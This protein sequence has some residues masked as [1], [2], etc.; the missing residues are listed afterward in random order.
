MR[1]SIRLFKIADIS[2]NV[3]ITF[4]LLLFLFLSMGFRW[5]FLIVAIFCFVILHELA[6]S[7]VAKKFGIKVNEITL[8]PIGGIASMSKMPDKPYQEFLISLA[9][10]MLNIG[11]VVIFFFPLYY[12]LGPEVLFHPLSVKTL[13]LTIAHIYWINLI[14]AAF[15]LIPAF[16]MDGG[17]ILR[18]LLAR[19]MGYRKATK[20]AVNFGHIFA[21]I[22]G[23]F[24]LVQGHIILI[25]IAIFIYMAASS[26]E[27]Q[28]DIRET[29]KR[30]TIK[31]IISPKF[32]TLQK[33]ATLAKVLELIFHSHQED[34]PI[35]EGGD[36]RMIGFVTRKD[37]I[38]GIHE[39]G[40]SASVTDIMRKDF[41]ILRETDFLNNA[42]NIMQEH[43]MRAL[44]I[45]KGGKVVGIVT[46]EDITRVYS[47][48]ADRK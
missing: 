37:I 34:F 13:P 12:L 29:L 4:F 8:L 41:P 6:H 20:I 47:V 42:Q 46:I 21:L 9:G 22:F 28:V 7:L 19:R 14:L 27:L 48:M 44:P 16:P 32:L 43:N 17:R 38:N 35:V 26:E 11:V 10:P 1:G 39:H 3:H 23:Y 25:I 18:S 40:T 36:G 5:F 24:G 45:V 30:F 33:D 31:D 2:I 15:N